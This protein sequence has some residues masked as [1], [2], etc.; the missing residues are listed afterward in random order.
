L[1]IAK[2][3]V[4][5]QGGRISAESEP[6]VGTSIIMTFPLENHPQTVE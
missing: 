1:A 2:A 6:G 5:A 4:E 3:L